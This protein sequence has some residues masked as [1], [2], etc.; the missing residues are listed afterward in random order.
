[1]IINI[2]FI[3]KVLQT[4][5]SFAVVIQS[6]QVTIYQNEHGNKLSGYKT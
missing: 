6:L 4:L 3:L 1:M 5:N 2:I